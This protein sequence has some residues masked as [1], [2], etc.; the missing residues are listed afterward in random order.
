MVPS[1]NCTNHGTPL[2]DKC[3]CTSQFTGPLCQCPVCRNN[4]SCITVNDTFGYCNCTPGYTGNNCLQCELF[5][6]LSAQYCQN[7]V[8]VEC[9]QNITS[10]NGAVTNVSLGIVILNSA[11]M[12]ANSSS[13]ILGGM[14][15]FLSYSAINHFGYYSN[16]VV[17]QFNTANTSTTV[18]YD[19]RL[20]H[21]ALVLLGPPDTSC[22]SQ[23]TLLALYN[24]INN[25][26]FVPGSQVLVF[27]NTP[28]G[29]VSKMDALHKLIALK[30]PKVSSC[31]AYIQCIRSVC[32]LCFCCWRTPETAETC[33]LQT[34][35]TPFWRTLIGWRN[36]LAGSLLEQWM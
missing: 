21:N 4:G 28:V 36:F 25:P 11:S 10:P 29:N 31:T 26:E 24:T 22:D 30:R 7:Y 18:V 9:T 20:V 13:D 15:Y 17:T 14:D 35:T 2:G 27:T 8:S 5:S 12:L 33:S 3:L 23:Q 34:L 16:F 6:C 32:S 1:V 19:W